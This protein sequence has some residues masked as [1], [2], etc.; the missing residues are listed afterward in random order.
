MSVTTAIILDLRRMNKETKNYPGAI[1]VTFLRQSRLYPVG[2][3]VS[4]KEF[5]NLFSPKAIPY[6]NEKLRESKEKLENEEQRAKKII[7]NINNFSFPAF[8]EAFQTFQPDRRWKKATP[9]AAPPAIEPPPQS[10]SPTS[11]APRLKPRT[12][13]VNQFGERKYPQKKSE[14]NFKALGE[15]AFYYG[16]KICKLEAKEQVVTAGVYFS[17]LTSLLKY[18]P[19]L[20]FAEITDMMLYDY[21]NWM[22][23]QKGTGATVSMYLR[24]LRHIFNQAIKKKVVSREDYPF[25]PEAY[26]VS[27][28]RKKKKALD[29]EYIRELYTYQSESR[30]EMMCR[31]LWFY[32]YLGNGMNVKDMAL[33]KFENMEGRFTRFYRAKTINTTRD[34]QQQISFYCDDVIMGI[35]GSW[36]N[37]DRR[38]D[39]YIFPILEPGLNAFEIRHKVQLFIHMMNNNMYKIAAKLNLPIRPATKGA[40]SAFA[41]QLK[42]TGATPEQVREL[43]GHHDLR[44]TQLYLDD[45]KDETKVENA[46]KLLPFRNTK[47]HMGAAEAV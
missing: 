36:G 8:A 29:I 34:D 13:F 31:D 22:K 16:I 38:P 4:K 20:R 24:C 32:I 5:K 25:G 3:E 21:E 17:S 35:I 41:T 6:L 12:K 10:G 7:H 46:Q 39:N 18:K 1:R 9:K 26:V 23:G 42:R 19:Q 27:G 45:Y 30:S 15:V 40:R 37:P 2:V 33:M 11:P 28:G 44:T 43:L 14:V 47:V